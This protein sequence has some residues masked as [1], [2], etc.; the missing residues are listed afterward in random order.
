MNLIHAVINNLTNNAA[1]FTPRGGSI[2]ITTRLVFPL[3]PYESPN[4]EEASD[5]SPRFCGADWDAR[6]NRGSV[7]GSYKGSTSPTA[8]SGVL[9]H[10][11]LKELEQKTPPTDKVMV[12]RIEVKDSGVGI[13][14]ADMYALALPSFLYF[15]LGGYTK[16]IPFFVSAGPTTGCFLLT[17]K[18]KLGDAKEERELD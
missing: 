5:P 8:V 11:R 3:V 13:K 10:T 17:F 14:R 6:S 12:A 4:E 1:K 9:S 18:P 16:L 7:N 15:G 2:T